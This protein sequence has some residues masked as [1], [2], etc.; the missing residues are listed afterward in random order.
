LSV[1]NVEIINF[2]KEPI[3]VS[4]RLHTDPILKKPTPG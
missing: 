2:R 4:M 1:P 3:P